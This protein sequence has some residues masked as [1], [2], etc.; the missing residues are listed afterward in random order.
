MLDA[1][2]CCM[3]YSARTLMHAIIVH[4]PD[5]SLYLES[6][7]SHALAVFGDHVG[8]FLLGVVG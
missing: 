8:A 5:T 1:A 6:K 3:L 2:P 4:V 7:A